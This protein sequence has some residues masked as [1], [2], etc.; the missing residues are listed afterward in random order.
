[1]ETLPYENFAPDLANFPQKGTNGIVIFTAKSGFL[2]GKMRNPS[3]F[4][5]GLVQALILLSSQF[6][7]AG[8]EAKDSLSQAKPQSSRSIQWNFRVGAA[9]RNLGD[10][11]FNSGAYSSPGLLPT[12]QPILGAGRASG[13]DELGVGALGAFADRSYVDGFVFIDGATA[14]PSSFLP[15]TTAY[16]GYQSDNQVR[17][18]SL[19]YSGGEYSTFS[20][21]SSNSSTPSDWSSGIDGASPVLELE[22]LLPIDDHWSVGGAVSFLFISADSSNSATSFRALRSMSESS[23]AVNDR[24]DLQGV[25]P[26]LAPYGGTLISPGTAPLIDNI[27]T[28]RIISQ[29]G[30]SIQTANFFNEV[31]E[32]IK[33]HLYTL[34]LGPTLHY[35][36]DKF[37]FSGGLG[38]AVNVADWNSSFDE[39]LNQTSGGST[40]ELR[41]WR[42]RSGDKEILPGFY[43]QGSAGYQITDHWQFSVFGR[44]DWSESLEGNVGPSSFSAELG[45]YTLGGSVTFTF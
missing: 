13:I 35:D 40:T 27:P 42:D 21:Q 10:I 1:M 9:Y 22:G 20:S 30:D 3:V 34:S 39:K 28:E 6:S 23:F 25:I 26:P 12:L 15:G 31:S 4:R 44:Y 8:Q 16:W 17:N 24:Y 18:G 33:I 41:K 19:Y 29:T 2:L 38:L 45:G 32:S 7:N 11:D 5:I 37:D 36:T 43:V 14:D